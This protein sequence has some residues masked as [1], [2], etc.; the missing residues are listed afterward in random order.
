MQ[1]RYGY[2]NINKEITTPIFIFRNSGKVTDRGRRISSPTEQSTHGPYDCADV[3]CPNMRKL[4]LMPHVVQGSKREWLCCSEYLCHYGSESTKADRAVAAHVL[5]WGK[6]RF[7]GQ[8]VH[9]VTVE[10]RNIIILITSYD[11]L[12]RLHRSYS[13]TIISLD[14][15]TSQTCPLPSDACARKVETS[16]LWIPFKPDSSHESLWRIRRENVELSKLSKRRW[17]TIHRF[18]L[19]MGDAQ[20]SRHRRCLVRVVMRE[21]SGSWEEAWIC[22]FRHRPVCQRGYEGCCRESTPPSKASM[23]I[24]IGPIIASDSYW[25]GFMISFFHCCEISV[26]FLS[27]MSR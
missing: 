7:Q 11:Q 8:F 21:E 13:C 20:H 2:E 10:E 24:T 15:R 5:V 17:N 22:G 19:D 27:D 16:L 9:A 26:V 1:G 14:I 25:A 3:G 18:L 4:E 23:T 12:E 6:D